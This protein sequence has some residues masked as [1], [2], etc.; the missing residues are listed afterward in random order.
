MWSRRYHGLP[1]WVSVFIASAFMMQARRGVA[2]HV[3]IMARN[4]RA[5]SFHAHLVEAVSNCSSCILQ[6]GLV[7]SQPL[8]VRGGDEESTLVGLMQMTKGLMG[9]S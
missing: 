3:H 4:R 7:D 5:C 2:W 8:L 1:P 6:S 9:L